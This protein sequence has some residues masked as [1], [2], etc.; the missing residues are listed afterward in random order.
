MCF[1]IG[2]KKSPRTNLSVVNED[3]SNL[4]VRKSVELKLTG[5]SRL[6]V[7]NLL[8]FFP[9]T[10]RGL[11]SVGKVGGVNTLEYIKSRAGWLTHWHQIIR[12]R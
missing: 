3:G 1:L 2:L 12:T 4:E 6:D 8:L 5:K 11:L 7:S 9:E 10:L